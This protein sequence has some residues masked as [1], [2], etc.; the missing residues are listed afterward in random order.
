[1]PRDVVHAGWDAGEAGRSSLGG[2]SRLFF[3]ASRRIFVHW[4]GSKN[5]IKF[6]KIRPESLHSS[7]LLVSQVTV[8]VKIKLYIINSADVSNSATIVFS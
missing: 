5:G 3:G 6:V 4:N 8:I 1:M 7:H 2:C